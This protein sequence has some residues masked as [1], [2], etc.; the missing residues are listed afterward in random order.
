M[1]KILVV[2]DDQD[3]S[4]ALTDR[5]KRENY[6]VENAEDGGQALHLLKLAEFDAII[7]DWNLPD[8]TG[9][10]VL[11]ELRGHGVRTPV[12]M[13]TARSD[14][15]DK[16][17]GLDSGADD[18]L[19]KPFDPVELSARVRAM[20]RRGSGQS[21]NELRVGPFVLDSQKFRAYKN[22]EELQLQPK[23]FALLELFMRHPGEVF[24][25]EA[26]LA[27]VWASESETS[28]ESVRVYIGNLRKKIDSQGAA[29]FI[30]T[31]FKRGYR[32]AAED[33]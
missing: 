10:S 11:R 33:R 13:L 20:L 19:T 1:P 22:G 26:L 30:E 2:E 28:P 4:F 16:E 17:A 21:S 32:F 14:V 7:L 6:S 5:L 18:Y 23:E 29:S 3:L 12:L 25:A 24:S 31:A 9:L 27:R 8:M 15:Y